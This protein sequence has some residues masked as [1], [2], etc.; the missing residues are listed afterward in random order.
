[1]RDE[2]TA[3][4]GQR[5]LLPRSRVK[6]RPFAR[7][8][9][10]GS[11]LLAGCAELMNVPRSGERIGAGR[12]EWLEGCFVGIDLAHRRLLAAD[13][14]LGA[15]VGNDSDVAE[16]EPNR[17]HGMG[18]GDIRTTNLRRWSSRGMTD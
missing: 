12:Q 6:Q 11:K 14:A 4:D 10:D 1:M 5:F 3:L 15:S 9:R 17:A 16:T 8:H 2:S 18:H 13:A 7:C